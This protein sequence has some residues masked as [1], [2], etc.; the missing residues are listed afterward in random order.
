MVRRFTDYQLKLKNNMIYKL[1]EHKIKVGDILKGI[2]DLMDN[3]KAYIIYTDPPWSA[4]NLK[5]WE[6]NNLKDTGIVVKNDYLKL[7]YKFFEIANKFGKEWLIIEYSFK[8]NLLLENLNK[9][10]FNFLGIKKCLYKGGGK[11]L[12]FKIHIF[13]K[14]HK[15]LPDFFNKISE[16]DKDY[17]VVKKVVYPIAKKGEI[18]LDP[19]SGLG[20]SFRVALET[21]MI[22]RGNEL[23]KKRVLKSLKIYE[24]YGKN[25]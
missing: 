8:N 11:Y 3:Q 7:L 12:P 25:N 10:N 15:S 9:L 16:N 21:D 1:G 13:S 2:D 17:E 19:F 24:K 23:N 6:T 20:N 5:W 4:G 14:S 18:L 22:Y